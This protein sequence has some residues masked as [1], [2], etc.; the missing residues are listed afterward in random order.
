MDLLRNTSWPSPNPSQS[1]SVVAGLRPW[2][3]LSRS[4]C[5]SRVP[6]RFAPGKIIR[7]SSRHGP[8]RKHRARFGSWK[9]LGADQKLDTQTIEIAGCSD[10]ITRMYADEN[11]GVI[12]TALV[13]Y[14]PA[15]KIVGHTPAICY[16]AVGFERQAGPDD[17]TIKAGDAS[18][19]LRSFVFIKPDSLARERVNVYAG[20]RHAGHWTPDSSDSR[21]RFRHE[22][23][24]FKI[25]VQRHIGPG[26]RCPSGNPTEQFAAALI[27]ELER[28]LAAKRI[29]SA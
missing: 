15:E 10:Y 23:G 24:M 22:P 21:K 28:E 9:A 17:R 6:A 19:R 18:A 7:W 2:C 5:C 11:T 1:P 25:Q 27:A 20:F 16:P 3:T 14:G 4:R 13:A 12:V 8:P 26:E 29:P